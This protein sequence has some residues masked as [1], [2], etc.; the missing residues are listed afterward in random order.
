MKRSSPMHIGDGS[1]LGNPVAVH[2]YMSQ[3]LVTHRS[4]HQTLTTD[5]CV[6]YMNSLTAYDFIRI[7]PNYKADTILFSFS[8]FVRDFANG[9]SL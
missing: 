9:V 3:K 4:A 7:H 5:K 1:V 6:V 8:Q 2:V